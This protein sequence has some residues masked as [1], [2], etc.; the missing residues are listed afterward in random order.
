MSKE[1]D[2]K[3]L[4]KIQLQNSEFYQIENISQNDNLLTINFSDE[5]D[6]DSLLE[7]M[8]KQFDE[9]TSCY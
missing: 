6:I 2:T 8:H 9:H 1:G 5:T 7:D 3:M 4:E